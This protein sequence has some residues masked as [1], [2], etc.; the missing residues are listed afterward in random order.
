MLDGDWSSDVCSSDLMDQMEKQCVAETATPQ[1]GNA[2][3]QLQRYGE[4]NKGRS[5]PLAAAKADAAAHSTDTKLPTIDRF[6]AS[7]T[8][9]DPK[10]GQDAALGGAKPDVSQA[11]IQATAKAPV[12]H[13]RAAV[14]PFAPI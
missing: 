6:G 12:A 10:T 14:K 1:K 11:P 5:G 4:R 2:L 9:I 13:A 3:E 7:T 8:L